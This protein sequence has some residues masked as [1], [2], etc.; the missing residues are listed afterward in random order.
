MKNVDHGRQYAAQRR[1][2]NSYDPEG[3]ASTK[4]DD[5]LKATVGCSPLN[6]SMMRINS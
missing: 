1:A 3:Q 5:S 2:F 4:M 6:R